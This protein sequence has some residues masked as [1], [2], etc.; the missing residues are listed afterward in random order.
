MTMSDED[1]TRRGGKWLEPATDSAVDL[2]LEIEK[3]KFAIER[4]A[5]RL[6]ET[7]KLHKELGDTLHGEMGRYGT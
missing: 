2:Q 3:L 4:L 5:V 7:E 1:A 6:A